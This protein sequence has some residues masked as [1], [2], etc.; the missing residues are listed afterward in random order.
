VYEGKT[1][2]L[3]LKTS[4]FCIMVRYRRRRHFGAVGPIMSVAQAR[5]D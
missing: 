5:V 1:T 2:A 4:F 3:V